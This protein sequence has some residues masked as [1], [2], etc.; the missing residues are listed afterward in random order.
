MNET[1]QKNG[2]DNPEI[3]EIEEVEA[4]AEDATEEQRA[5]YYAK[6][7]SNNKQLYARLKKSQGFVQDKD[8]K[9]VKPSIP[10]QKTETK[11]ADTIKKETSD[12]SALDIYAIVQANVHKDDIETVTRFAKF[13]GISV[14]DALANDMLK[15]MLDKR[16]EL[17][18]VAEGTN[19]STAKRGNAKI[20]DDALLE[21]ARKGKLPENDEDLKRLTTLMRKK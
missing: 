6:L 20:S 16:A 10:S 18:R 12:L 17:R 1:V 19:T 7:E 5:E 4:L 11:P 3:V 9:W 14:S 2:N 8:G 13:E 15:S 21:N